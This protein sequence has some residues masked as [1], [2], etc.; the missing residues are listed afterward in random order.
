[1][2]KKKTETTDNE[3]HQAYLHHDDGERR[4]RSPRRISERGV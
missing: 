4:G 1:V 2:M 3:Q